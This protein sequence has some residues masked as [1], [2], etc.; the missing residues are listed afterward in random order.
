MS[1]A[2]VSCFFTILNLWVSGSRNLFQGKGRT[3]QLCLYKASVH[4]PCNVLIFTTVFI[5]SVISE[6][7][8]GPRSALKSS[9]TVDKDQLNLKLLLSALLEA[10]Q[11]SQSYHHYTKK[12]VS[13][14]SPPSA[15]R[16]SGGQRSRGQRGSSRGGAAD[17]N[18]NSRG[19]GG[20]ANFTFS[21]DR[22]RMIDMENQRLL[23]VCHAV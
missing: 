22:A 7:R 4:L 17:G 18:N 3:Q 11:E 20:K 21:T 12:H 13:I 1:D 19:S 23:N 15:S 8:G 2:K 9:D 10:D 6:S 14:H 16:S 5:I